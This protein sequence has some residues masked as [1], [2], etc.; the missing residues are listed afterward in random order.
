MPYQTLTYEKKEHVAFIG[1]LQATSNRARTARLSDELAELRTEMTRDSEIHVILLADIGEKSLSTESDSFKPILRESGE[2]RE[3]NFSS[4][5]EPIAKLDKPVIAA[6]KGNAIGQGL[7]LALACDIRIA[8]ETAR[9]GLPQVEYGVMPWDGG[10]Q[11]LARLVG[12]AKALEMILTGETIGAKE[13]YRIGLVN[14]VVSK[15]ELTKSAMDMAKEMASK[16]PIALTYT[17]EAV[18]K[19]MEMT[20]EQGLHLEADLYLLIH[21]TKDRTEGIRAFLEKRVPKFGGK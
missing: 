10:T 21:T 5:A 15:E 2:A 19:G 6:I 20:L 9:F 16:G 13:A 12:K 11:R 8:S 3:I 18:Y 1:L 14:K 17:K 7:E 4:L